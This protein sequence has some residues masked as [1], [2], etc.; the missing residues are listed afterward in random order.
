LV[1]FF[2]DLILLDQRA[3]DPKCAKQ[4]KSR[5]HHMTFVRLT[6]WCEGD[7][8]RHSAAKYD[9]PDIGP[10]GPLAVLPPPN[11]SNRHKPQE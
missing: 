8:N 2:F 5:E 9:L 3:A 6:V 7:R 1:K 4:A 10:G 11:G